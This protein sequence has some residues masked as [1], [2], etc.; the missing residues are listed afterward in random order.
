MI[1]NG[2]YS[3]LLFHGGQYLAVD[4]LSF[5]R[6]PAVL[7][8]LAKSWRSVDWKR[9]VL[10]NGLW[11]KAPGWVRSSVRRLRKPDRRSGWHQM[12][13]W[14]FVDRTHLSDRLHPTEESHSG[15]RADFLPRW[16]HMTMSVLAQGAASARRLYNSRATEL[17]DPFWDRS[18]VE[19]VMA[20]PAHMLARPG[21]TKYLLR[22]AMAG[23]VPEEVCQR[24]DKT[25]LYELF[26][27]GLLKRER[28]TVLGLLE[29]PKIVER[30]MVRGRWLTGQIT[31]GSDW[32]DYGHP[33]WRCLNV[34]LW[35]RDQQI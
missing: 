26:C 8:I 18:L 13:E 32:S 11:M 25:S 15:S 31:A 29:R 12:L 4:L 5:R 7:S 6:S 23:A 35:L 17:V 24:R 19:Y 30:N 9:D 21:V 22:Q 3:D 16:R 10:R 33:L 20:L 34:E 27:E 28:G 14:E 2:H 1:L